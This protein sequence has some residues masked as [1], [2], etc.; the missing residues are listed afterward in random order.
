MR[1]IAVAA[2]VLVLAGCS[3]KAGFTV[4]D[5]RFQ[6]PLGASEV[7][8]GYFSIR[9]AKADAIVK[10]SSPAAKAV[11]IHDMEMTGDMMSMERRDSIDLPA[12]KKIEFKPNGLHLMV[13]SPDLT[14]HP[15]S[16]PITIELRS[17]LT[18]TVEFAARK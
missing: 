18:Q 2:F 17:G 4:A 11:E 6:P 10:V 13:F 14:G 15:A 16:F 5:A 3:A 1:W 9:S 8:A 7:G 12:G